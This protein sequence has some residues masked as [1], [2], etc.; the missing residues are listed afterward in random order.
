MR[1]P[2]FS[3]AGSAASDASE[4]TLSDAVW[5]RCLTSKMIA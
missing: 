4:I 2:F 3:Y 5:T 1:R